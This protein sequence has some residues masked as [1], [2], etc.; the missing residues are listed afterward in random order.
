MLSPCLELQEDDT[1]PLTVIALWCVAFAILMGWSRHIEQSN[2]HHRP[3]PPIDAAAVEPVRVVRE[4]RHAEREGEGHQQHH[5]FPAPS[6]PPAEDEGQVE[7]AAAAVPPSVPDNRADCPICIDKLAWPVNTNCGHSYCC[8]CFISYH[9]QQS[10]GQIV[11]SPVRCPC[12]RRAVD[13]I[14]PTEPG[15]TPEEERSE[16]GAQMR[17]HI[18]EYNRLFSN[19]PRSWTSILRDTP[20]LLQ[21]FWRELLSGGPA[22]FA[23]LRQIRLWIIVGSAL[24]YVLSPFDIIPEVMFGFFGVLDDLMVLIIVAVMVGGIVRSIAL[25]R[26]QVQQMGGG[27]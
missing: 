26:T 22:T 12:C 24:L 1:S 25:Q 20:V 14:L 17:R 15:W 16:T 11:R 18:A 3:P 21:R 2:Q 8:Q 13:A 4:R 23:L 9:Q 7:G 10:R 27:W 19:E 5:A 6:A